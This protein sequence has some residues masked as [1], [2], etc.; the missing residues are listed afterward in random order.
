MTHLW[1]STAG[2]W[3]ACAVLLLAGAQ[4]WAGP[5]RQDAA[6]AA[7]VLAAKMD[8]R[9]A[10]HWKDN[11]VQPAPLSD[12]AEFLRRVYLDVVG[13]IP[14]AGEARRFLDDRAAD[15]RRRLVA[16]L[17]TGPRYVTHWGNVWRS[18]LLPELKTLD[19]FKVD[20]NLGGL[21]SFDAWLHKHLENN[22]AYD[23]M[24]REL[25]TA[26]VD[27]LI[28]AGSIVLVPRSAEPSPLAF[29]AAKEAKP[30]NLA[31]STARLF[32]GVRVECAQCHD[33]PFAQWKREQFW[34][35]A[36]FFAG[37]QAPGG[38]RSVSPFRDNLGPKNLA[39]PSTDK[40][41]AAR[42]LDGSVPRW[43][44]RAGGRQVLADW[45]TSAKNPYFARA[46]ANRLWAHFFGTGLV[47]PVDDMVGKETQDND[48]GGLLD[49][50]AGALVAHDFDLKFLMRAITGSKAYQLS[51]ARTHPN[52]D[53]PRMFSRM[54]VRG[55]TGE[56]LFDSLAQVTGH[57]GDRQPL[58][59]T[60]RGIVFHNK[61]RKEFLARFAN[62]SDKAT[63]AQTSVQQALALMNGAIV[64]DA[65]TLA[66]SR[67]LRAL[68]D[69]PLMDTAQ[70]VEALYLSTL[71]R[72]PRPNELKR[73][74]KHVEQGSTTAEKT[75]ALADVL[76]VLLNCAELKL[77]H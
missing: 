6:G 77:N 12:D 36:A 15:K 68:V 32:L 23:K 11:K 7:Q 50:L 19:D 3:L 59:A 26:P 34:N 57:E 53:D 52:Q 25:L 55:L 5:A 18:L 69:F 16:S 45:I 40:M 41:V 37:L 14:S 51:S 39:I 49:E 54:A 56:Q 72:L 71:S 17:L 63:E 58:G 31:A 13:R 20:F 27:G 35:Q 1:I 44:E 62:P 10:R 22:V 21:Q 4:A 38:G 67:P 29:Y 76:W 42:F 24:V 74:V 75:D 48:P 33:H 70:R 43:P 61:V 9:L 8:D 28:R 46:A 64:A 60:S 65:T 66:R 73:M 47:E 30:D 2:R